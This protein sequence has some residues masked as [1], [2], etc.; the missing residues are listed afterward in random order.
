M[1][2]VP[3]TGLYESKG[4]VGFKNLAAGRYEMEIQ[5]ASWEKAKTGADMFVV[6]T[7]VTNVEDEKLLEQEPDPIGRN[8]T[9]RFVISDPPLDFQIDGLKNFLN[10]LGVKTAK[11]GTFSDNACV[12][13][14]FWVRAGIGL[15]KQTKAEEQKW[16]EF[17]PVEG[18]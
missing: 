15:N 16:Y 9:L 6:K 3:V 17:F 4:D 1:A 12:E 14:K 10:S 18:E 13:K 8:M 7:V 2:K 11:D 5:A